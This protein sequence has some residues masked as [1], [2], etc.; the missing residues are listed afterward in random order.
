LKKN[1]GRKLIGGWNWNRLS[2]LAFQFSLEKVTASKH[3]NVFPTRVTRF[4]EFS[5]IG[6]FFWQ[7]LKTT[8]E[9]Q[10]FGLLVPTGK[11]LFIKFDKK[12]V[13]PRFGPYFHKVIMMSPCFQRCILLAEQ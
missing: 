1:I 10:M 2:V 7:L 12:W 13:G 5:P 3:R 6:W 4:S 11:K 9:A 8:E